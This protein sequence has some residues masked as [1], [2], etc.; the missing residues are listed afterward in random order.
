[1]WKV[2]TINHPWRTA[3]AVA[4]GLVAVAASLYI[5]ILLEIVK[6]STVRRRRGQQAE[7]RRSA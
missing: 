2:W 4:I 5:A 7:E 6:L 1:M 3:A